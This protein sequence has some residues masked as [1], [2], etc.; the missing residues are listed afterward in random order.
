MDEV[1][2]SKNA[3]KQLKKLDKQIA[4]MLLLWIEKNLNN[5]NDPRSIGKGLVGNNKKIWK[6]HIGNYRLLCNIQDNKLLILVIDA[7]HRKDIYKWKGC[8]NCSFFYS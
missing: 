8:R 3:I 7:G 4:K 2:F 1:V 5:I 6:Y